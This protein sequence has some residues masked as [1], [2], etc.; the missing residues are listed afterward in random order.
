[1]TSSPIDC[2]VNF[3]LRMKELRVSELCIWPVCMFV[4]ESARFVPTL[5][6]DACIGFSFFL[7]GNWK[8]IFHRWRKITLISR[9]LSHLA[10][11][12]VQKTVAFL[13]VAVLSPAEKSGC[14]Y[15]WHFHTR[16][17]ALIGRVYSRTHL[18]LQC[19]YHPVVC[20]RGCMKKHLLWPS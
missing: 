9:W 15:L 5:L 18:S 19:I 2:T 4:I 16:E 6:G 13:W 11:S 20:L 8:G 3:L 14:L 7:L 17:D 10:V 1:M 12:E